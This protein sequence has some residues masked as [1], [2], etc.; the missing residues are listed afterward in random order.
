MPSG[1][2]VLDVNHSWMIYWLLNSYYLI[3]NPTMEINQSILDL[4]VN[5]ITKCINYGDSLSESLLMELVVVIIN[6]VIW[7]Q[8]MQRF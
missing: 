2:Q 4:I 6:W 3:Q 8:L 7:L 5:K 1:Y